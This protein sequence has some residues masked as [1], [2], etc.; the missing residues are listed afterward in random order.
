MQMKEKLNRIAAFILSVCMA[1]ACMPMTALAE[2]A[3]IPEDGI[4]VE[5]IPA[6][7]VDESA[8]VTPEDT[9]PQPEE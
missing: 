7:S 4:S 3:A 6:D 1:L 2:E 5:V 8:P 9:E